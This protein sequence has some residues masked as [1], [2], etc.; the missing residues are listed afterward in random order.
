MVA[1]LHGEMT[2]SHTLVGDA[3]RRGTSCS[4]TCALGLSLHGS[5]NAT[6]LPAGVWSAS[7]ATCRA[8]KCSVLAEVDHGRVLP[9][10]CTGR[11]TGVGQHCYL[12]CSPG[13]RV[14]GNP[15]RTCQ[16]SGLWSP[17]ASSPYCEKD[18]L[19]PFIQCPGDVQVD[20]APHQS[21]A[22]VRLPQPKANVDWFRY[23]DAAPEWAKQ[24]EAD[25]PAGKTSVSFVARSPVSEET[26]T[27]SFTVEVRDKEEPQVFRCPKSFTVVLT[28]SQVTT[29]V[30]WREPFFKDNVEVS[31]LWKSLEPGRHLTAGTYPVHYVAMDPFRN[32][33]K[34]SFVITVQRE[35]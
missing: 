5:H 11:T 28:E 35:F 33:A 9:K 24:L 19:K 12:T 25:L 23:V 32:R 31:H 29:K 7:P 17:E 14:V 15:V 4:F 22:H 1:P 3:Y 34:C 2:C 21:S 13:Y 30:S 18:S 10:R 6:C 27:C 8:R 16:T 26:A 20:L